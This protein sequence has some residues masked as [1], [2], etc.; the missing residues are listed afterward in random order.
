[1]DGGTSKRVLGT[2]LMWKAEN[3]ARVFIVVTANDI[4][5]LPPELMWKGRLDEFFFVD[6][7]DAGNRGVIFEIHLKK[8]NIDP[9]SFELDELTALADGFSWSEIE[10]AVVAGLYSAYARGTTLDQAVLVK[11][12]NVTRPLSVVMPEKLNYLRS[13]AADRKV[14]AN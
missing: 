8:R 13:W 14:P 3:S 5:S 1:M 6:L 2:L 9:A 10:Q 12:L 4:E 11:E 7:P